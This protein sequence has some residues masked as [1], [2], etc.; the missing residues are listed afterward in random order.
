M[1]GTGGALPEARTAGTDD[2]TYGQLAAARKPAWHQ[3]ACGVL[4]P[5]EHDTLT[6]FVQPI[7]TTIG[8]RPVDLGGTRKRYPGW[9]FSRE[10][11][12]LA[13]R[14]EDQLCTLRAGSPEALEA[15]RPEEQTRASMRAFRRQLALA[16]PAMTERASQVRGAR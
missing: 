8:A 6:R 11:Q 5:A 16:A 3:L 10:G 1:S 4:E 12:E 9:R 15:G 14:S 2:M 13:A 7:T